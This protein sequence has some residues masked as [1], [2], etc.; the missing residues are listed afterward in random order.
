MEALFYGK[1]YGLSKGTTAHDI[2]ANTRHWKEQPAHT[3]W[4]HP[5]ADVLVHIM[6]NLSDLNQIAKSPDFCIK[7]HNFYSIKSDFIRWCIMQAKLGTRKD[8][9][10]SIDR[11]EAA[12]GDCKHVAVALNITIAGHTWHVHQILESPLRWVLWDEV[13]GQPIHEFRAH[14]IKYAERSNVL[15]KWEDILTIIEANNWFIL[16]DADM[17][18]WFDIINKRY[19]H[20]FTK[21]N[22]VNR[23][24]KLGTMITGGP[25]MELS[26]GLNIRLVQLRRNFTDILYSNNLAGTFTLA[27]K[28]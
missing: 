8:I 10:Y 25:M 12:P 28:C 14:D 23:N 26:N 27:T 2:R 11:L 9:S 22:F 17:R 21:A 13:I 3:Y 24:W 18:G 5:S 6:N 4:N 20:L 1:E 19:P 15:E 16:D 7:K